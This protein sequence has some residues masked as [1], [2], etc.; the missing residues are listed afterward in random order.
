VVEEQVAHQVAEHPE[1]LT[2]KAKQDIQADEAVTLD[3]NHIQ[4]L[5]VEQVEPQ[6]FS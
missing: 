4:D 1:A 5:V 6:L 2:E 3:H